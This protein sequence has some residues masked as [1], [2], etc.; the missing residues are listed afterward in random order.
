ML[1]LPNSITLARIALIPVI[2]LQVM[3]RNYEPAFWLFV[4]CAVGDALDGYLAR[5]LNLR[6]R[7]GSVADPLADKFTMLIVTLLLASQAWIPWW[8]ALL[9]VARDIVIVIGALAWHVRIGPVEMAP[10]RLSKVNT[11]LE[12]IFIAAVLWQAH[13]QLDDLLW[14]TDGLLWVT[15]AT[16]LVSGLQYVWVWGRRALQ[17]ERLVR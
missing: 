13:G 8:F 2:A 16:V 12:F 1:N 15:S 9:S 7:F 6:T 10:T 5:R 14:I 17:V 11:L 3:E 4:L